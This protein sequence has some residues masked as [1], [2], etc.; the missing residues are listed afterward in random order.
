MSYEEQIVQLRQRLQQPLPGFAAQERMIGRLISMPPKVPAD[1]RPSAVLCLLFPV[2]GALHM[3]LMKRM[4]DNT[5]HS[6]QVSF[7]GGRYEE[8]D[9]DFKATALREANEEV[10]ILSGEVEILGALTSLYIP[11]SNFNVYPFVGFAAKQPEYNLSH[12]EVAYTLEVPLSEL[13]H[14]QRKTITEVRS[15]KFPDMVREV[16]AYVLEDKTVI[17]GA[18]AMI[19]SELEVLMEGLG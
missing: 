2:D 6:G 17:W 13:F 12:A 4:E 5:A 19:I 9:A 15:P 18:T 14:P 16:N 1:A 11:V 8:S 10:G 7:P 3:L